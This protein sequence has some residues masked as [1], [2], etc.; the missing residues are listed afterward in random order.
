ML[1][2]RPHRTNSLHH[3]S[4]CLS[5]LAQ[6]VALY[7][8]ELLAGF[9]L[10]DAPAYEEWLA[11]RRELLHQK[12]LM[13]LKNLADAF[14]AQGELTKAHHYASRQLRLD[15]YQEHTHRQVMR[16]LARRGL[17]DQALA[18]IRQVT[19]TPAR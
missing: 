19:P 5:Q 1:P 15:P 4:A 13:T 8:D 6:A 7:Q 18:Q 11:L 16:T 3:C 10:P 14:E 9:S 12:A 2:S 17:P